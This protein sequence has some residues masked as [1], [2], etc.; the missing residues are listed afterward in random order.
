MGTM[1]H[2]GRELIRINP[3]NEQKLEYSANDGRTWVTR[4]SSAICG[5]FEE[6]LDNGKEILA[7]T[8]K[9]LFFST[10]DGRTWAKRH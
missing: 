8:S 10:N 7:T 2:R 3:D 9:G 1:I 5:D 6:L 4:Y